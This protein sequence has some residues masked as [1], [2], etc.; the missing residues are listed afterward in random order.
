MVQVATESY[1]PDDPE[2]LDESPVEFS[3]GWVAAR[4]G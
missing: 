1:S 3:G 2:E 4:G